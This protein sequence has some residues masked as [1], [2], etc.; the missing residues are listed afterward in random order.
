MTLDD[1]HARVDYEGDCWLWNGACAKES[2][3]GRAWHNNREVQAQVVSWLLHHGDIP[4]EMPYVLQKCREKRCVNPAHLYLAEMREGNLEEAFFA[5]VRKTDTC[6]IWT[7]GS[8]RGYGTLEVVQWHGKKKERIL[9]RAHRLSWKIHFGDPGDLNVCHNCP[10]GDNPLCV[11]PAHLWLGTQNDNVQ[12][13]LQKRRGKFVRGEQHGCAKLTQKQV[14]A[15]RR[16]YGAGYESYKTLA[17]TY[18]VTKTLIA[19]I[20]H[21]KAWTH[22]E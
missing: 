8:I 12:D 5:R 22:V 15:I 6:W 4:I 18:G 19:A 16:A 10:G 2:G 21:R 3:Y 14:L 11:N 13:M 7:G 17:E 9:Y 20:V 1:L